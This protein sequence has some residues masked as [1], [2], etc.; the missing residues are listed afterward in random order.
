MQALKSIKHCFFSACPALNEIVDG[1]VKLIGTL[2][3][4]RQAILVAMDTE[5]LEG[6][7]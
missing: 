5:W 7:H 4:V 2:L 6:Q 1:A 3:G